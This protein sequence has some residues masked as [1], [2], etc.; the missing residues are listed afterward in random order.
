M[1]RS[2]R[3]ALIF[4]ENNTLADDMIVCVRVVQN[5]KRHTYICSPSQA[6]NHMMFSEF[7]WFDFNPHI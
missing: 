3:K 7:V 1:T 6:L 5:G 2:K 4:C